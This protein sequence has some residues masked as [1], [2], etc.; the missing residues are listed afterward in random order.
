MVCIKSIE[1]FFPDVTDAWRV[2]KVRL[3]TTEPARCEHATTYS[4]ARKKLLYIYI[5]FFFQVQSSIYVAYISSYLY[6][7]YIYTKRSCWSI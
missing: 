5:Y 3:L 2:L 4:H 6:S 1:K 7:F